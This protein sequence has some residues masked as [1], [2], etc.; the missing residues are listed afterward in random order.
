[1]P[2]DQALL[3]A[4]SLTTPKPKTALVADLFCGAG[5]SSTGAK[6]ALSELGYR[7]NLV[8]VNH[9]DTAID[10]HT[11]NHPEARHYCADVSAVRPHI[12]VPEGRLDLLMASPTCTFH[13]RARGGKPVSDQ[14]RMDPWHII[15]WLTELKVDRLLVE[16]VPEFVKWGPVSPRTGK[17]IKSKEGEYFDRWVETICNLG[18]RFDH[19]F[20]NCA[21]YG[22]A[23]TRERWFGQA[24]FDRVKIT[25][26]EASHAKR[27]KVIDLFAA[28][29]KPWRAAREIID[30]NVRGRSIFNR[31]IPLSP[32]T[33]E[34]ILAGAIKLR[35]P[36][37]YIVAIEAGAPR[38]SAPRR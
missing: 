27:G 9:W 25:W 21:D 10:T 1:M 8:C 26:P 3:E 36:E 30:W 31:P 18:G 16:N 2:R 37:L 38:A 29:R 20:L 13:S 24:R 4:T 34:R 28:G 33:L 23:T 17:P 19:R 15:G 5:G 6:R 22:D 14:Q 32:R 11:K 7:M 12:A 35:W